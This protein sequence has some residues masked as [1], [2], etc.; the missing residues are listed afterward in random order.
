MRKLIERFRSMDTRMQKLVSYL[1][2][3]LAVALLFGL[4]WW[5]VAQDKQTERSEAD[6]P[7][8]LDTTLMIVQVVFKIL[9]VFA[10]MFLLF[11]ALRKWQNW[12]PGGTHKRL[13]IVETIR[14]SQRQAIHLV[15]VDAHQFLVGATDQSLTLLSEL[16]NAEQIAAV[17]ASNQNQSESFDSLVRSFF[18]PARPSHEGSQGGSSRLSF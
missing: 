6:T 7:Y 10:L 1:G 8:A 17:A 2:Y 5:S 16:D 18:E 9:L 4:A 3:F 14:L 12:R 13:A 11:A 15:Q